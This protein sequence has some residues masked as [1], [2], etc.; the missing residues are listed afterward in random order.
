ML[1]SLRNIIFPKSSGKPSAVLA[2]G[3]FGG[4]MRIIHLRPEDGEIER[5][6][7]SPFPTTFRYGGAVEQSREELGEVTLY[8]GHDDADETVYNFLDDISARMR[9][10]YSSGMTLAQLVQD[11]FRPVAL[12]AI[13]KRKGRERLMSPTETFPVYLVYVMRSSERIG[14]GPPTSIR[15]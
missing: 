1:S 6:G 13:H 8:A 14:T 4:M 11:I 3:H 5:I 10:Q 9:S 2:V 12:N 7:G 15:H